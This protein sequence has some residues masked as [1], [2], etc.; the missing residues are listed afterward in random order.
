V[1]T[2]DLETGLIT[3][4][5]G[6]LRGMDYVLDQARIRGIRVLLVLTDYF[7]NGAGGPLQY[8]GFQTSLDTDGLSQNDIKAAWFINSEARG[9]FK[10]YIQTVVTRRNTI[11]GRL[12]NEDPT[13]MGWDVMNEPRCQD[14]AICFDAETP[15]RVLTEWIDDISTYV[16]SLDERHLITV[17][18][19]GFYLQPPSRAATYPTGLNPF[20][21]AATYN[22]DFVLN[23]DLPNIDFLSFNV[24]PDFY[25]QENV[26]WIRDWIRGHSVDAASQLTKPAIIKELGTQPTS[27][28]NRFYE[29]M[30]K[31]AFNVIRQTT[32]DVGGGGLQGAMYWQVRFSFV[33]SLFLSLSFYTFLTLSSLTGLCQRYQSGMVAVESGGEDRHICQRYCVYLRERLCNKDC[34]AGGGCADAAVPSGPMAAAGDA[35]GS[36]LPKG[37]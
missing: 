3:I 33:S 4:N 34:Q 31:I 20:S 14:Q 28:R 30:Y 24:Y 13:V 1:L 12:Y 11:N 8:M 37:I 7:A 2:K 17:G 18:L 25:G 5:E 22:S 36:I 26:P 16:R 32:R 6:V 35:A 29:E 23:S 15:G 9:I 10:D 21:I 19:D 27:N